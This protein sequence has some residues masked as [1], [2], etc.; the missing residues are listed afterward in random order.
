MLAQ[1]GM[2]GVTFVIAGD[3]RRQRL[4]ETGVQLRGGASL[5]GGIDLHRSLPRDRADHRGVRRPR[6]LG[7]AHACQQVAAL[8]VA[9][10][11]QD[12]DAVVTDRG[13]IRMARRC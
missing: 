6:C 9:D 10:W 8:P 4:P 1:N 12:V 2:T 5:G 13:V 11:D 7:L 3:D